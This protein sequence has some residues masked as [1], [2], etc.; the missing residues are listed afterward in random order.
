MAA[1]ISPVRRRGELFLEKFAGALDFQPAHARAGKHVAARPD[2][3]RHLREAMPARRMIVTHVAHQPA[4][5]RGDAD[6][7]NFGGLSCG[8][9][10]GEFK[11]GADGSGIPQPFG[12]LIHFG[13]RDVKFFQQLRRALGF[14]IVSAA[15]GPD[16]AAPETVAANQR[17]E[18]EKIAANFSARGS[19]GQ[20]RHVVGQ[21]A[22]VAG[23]VRQ[24]FQFERD[25]PQPLRAQR[26]F[27]AG[28]RFEDGRVSRR[29]ADGRV[30]GDGFH[31]AHRRAMRPARERLLDAAMLVAERDFQMQHFLAVALKTKMARLNDA[32]VNR[33]DRDFVNLAA[34]HAEKISVRRMVAVLP[35]HGFQ[36]R[37]AF[38]HEAVLFPD[39]ALEQMRLRMQHA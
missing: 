17:G 16:E 23:V 10:A 5:A 7:T 19:C 29:V 9:R 31:L 2:R 20:K 22:E 15:A 3:H 8:N 28:E 34:F 14:Q 18:I 24:P 37:M 4:G 13:Q 27:R 33:P 25:G 6:Q 26:R 39:F 32:R 30:A 36:P 21:R 35:A 1:K 11:A 38:G 12:R